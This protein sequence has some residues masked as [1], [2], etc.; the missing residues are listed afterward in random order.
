MRPRLS[1]RGRSPS[2]AA[3]RSLFGELGET[4]CAHGYIDQM[5]GFADRHRIGY[6]GWAWDAALGGWTAAPPGRR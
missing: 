5:M 1:G 3:I 4:D 2:R 6:L